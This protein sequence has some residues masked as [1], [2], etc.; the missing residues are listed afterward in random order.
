MEYVLL[1]ERE[2]ERERKGKRKRKSLILETFALLMS[3]TRSAVFCFYWKYI[4][5]YEFLKEEETMAFP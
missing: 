3:D 4:R 5:L 2:T 1:S